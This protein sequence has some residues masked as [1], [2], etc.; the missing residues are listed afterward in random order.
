[1][2][3][4][5]VFCFLLMFVFCQVF[6]AQPLRKP[7]VELFIGSKRVPDGS[8]IEVNKGDR[9][10]LMAQIK[11]GRAD[12][13]QLP[14]TYA[15]FG[16]TAQVVSRGYN[17]LIYREKGKE[18][19]WELTNEKIEFESDN[20]IRLSINSELT[21]KHEVDVVIPAVKVDKSY[22]KIKLTTTWSFSDGATTKT[23]E[24]VAEAVVL[25]KIHGNTN[26]WYASPNLK[27]TGTSNPVVEQKL[28]EI[29]DS[30]RKIETMLSEFN[31]AP[32]Q[33]EIRSLQSSINELGSQIQASNAKDPVNHTDVIFI[34]LPS[35]RSISDIAGFQ[36]LSEAWIQLEQLLNEQHDKLS[37]AGQLGRSELLAAIKPFTQWQKSLPDNTETLL[38]KYAKDIDWQTITINSYLSFNPEEER[39]NNLE[40]C[41]ADLHRF[42]DNRQENIAPEKQKLQYALT[43]LQAVKIFDGMLMGLFS[44]INYATWE[45]RR[46]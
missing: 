28:N 15:D 11:G 40:Q 17:K 13:V 10:T 27:A 29:Q 8:M 5:V 45:N 25:L 23:E 38:S 44:S 37:N 33:S 39:L 22:I 1:M 21:N 46:N 41:Q 19:Q 18:Y 4:A 36:A 3:R 7:F 30:Y 2:K 14:D 43:R 24:N 26:E 6:S 31:F 32:V 9:F 20:K 12:F 42:L 35:D 34:G 16:A